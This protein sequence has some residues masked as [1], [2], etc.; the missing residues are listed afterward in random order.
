[1]MVYIVLILGGLLFA[2]L[3][4]FPLVHESWLRKEKP[5]DRAMRG[6]KGGKG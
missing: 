1:M 3:S 6:I 4:L 2:S 5:L